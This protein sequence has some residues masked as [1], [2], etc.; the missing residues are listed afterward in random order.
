MDTA[1]ASLSGRVAF[2]NP[3]GY[4]PAE[5]YGLLPFQFGRVIAVILVSLLF[6]F[7]RWRHADA[8]VP[9]HDGILAVCGVFLLDSAVCLLAYSLLNRSGEPDCCPFAAPM[10][11]TLTVQIFR[12]VRSQN[13]RNLYTS[14]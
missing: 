10:I 2:R 14:L 6:I 5:Y 11:A 13:S 8:I 4:F 3:Y 9:L 12:Q 1:A 7:F